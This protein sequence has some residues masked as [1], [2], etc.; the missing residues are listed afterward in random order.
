MSGIRKTFSLLLLLSLAGCAVANKRS[1]VL[2]HELSGEGPQALS[3][4]NP[5]LAPN[6]F[7]SREMERS[8]FVSGFIKFRGVPDA[9]EV[10][11]R[12]F[13]PFRLYAFYL[14]T[15]DGY[16]LEERGKE[17]VIRGPEKIPTALLPSLAALQAGA[18]GEKPLLT[19]APPPPE[20][21]IGPRPNRAML[22]RET[23]PRASQ[24]ARIEIS[25]SG[26]LLHYVTFHGETLRLITEW[27]TKDVG[28]AERLARING[29]SDP[30]ILQLDQVV[31]IPRY[32]LKNAA[33]LEEGAVIDR[34]KAWQ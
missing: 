8:E 18:R 14:D 3:T 10:K 2:R 6:L 29:F 15:N 24:V 7:L 32:M 19:A 22:E 13:Q 20:S 12:F 25:S 5:Y 33:P 23:K 4:S 1:N 30:N 34:L 21:Q 26:D 9:I 11:Q 31:R 27:Y 16:V 17:W 28:N